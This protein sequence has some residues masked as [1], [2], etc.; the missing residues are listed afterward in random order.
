[1]DSVGQGTTHHHTKI[2]RKEDG[3]DR[4]GNG[5]GTEKGGQF[6]SKVEMAETMGKVKERRDNGTVDRS[7]LGTA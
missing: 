4:K 1:M 5:K 3:R 2:H 6:S 7:I